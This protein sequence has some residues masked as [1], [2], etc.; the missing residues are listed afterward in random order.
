MSGQQASR[1][2]YELEEAY[3]PLIG[4][5]LEQVITEGESEWEQQQEIEWV[6]LNHEP[7]WLHSVIVRSLKKRHK[8]VPTASAAERLALKLGIAIVRER[9]GERIR[10]IDG[11]WSHIFNSGNQH[12]LMK[13]YKTARY[14]LQETAAT[15]YRKCS[16]RRWVAGA[17]TDNLVDPLNLSAA[18]AV[19]LT[20]VAGISAS[21]KWVPSAWRKLAEKELCNFEGY[22]DSETHKLRAII[23]DLAP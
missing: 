2:D 7:Q 5:S 1:E 14:E 15:T 17:I 13:S 10:E 16:A 11:L 9:F 22:L 4:K 23:A 3:Q 21:E 20:L 19:V 6:T 18:T 8:N 12:S